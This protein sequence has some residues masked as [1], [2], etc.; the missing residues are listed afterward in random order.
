MKLWQKQH[1]LKA[2]QQLHSGELESPISVATLIWAVMFC[3]LALG[4]VAVYS[5][6]TFKA[7]VTYN[8]PY[9]FVKKHSIFVAVA[10]G[11]TLF[12][13]QLPRSF[14]KVMALPSTIFVAA[15]M[16]FSLF[17]PLAETAGGATRWLDL[18]FVRFQPSE[19]IKVCLPLCCAY[20]FSR[21]QQ[22]ALVTKTLL[23]TGYFVTILM[24]QPDFGTSSLLLGYTFAGLFLAGVSWRIL[25]VLTSSGLTFAVLAIA[26]SE[27][28]MRRVLSFL[29]P[30]SQPDTN[31]FQIIQSYLGINAGGIL[32]LGIG[33]SKQKL[34]F[35][36][37]PHTDFILS[38]VG[39]EMGLLGII[40]LILLFFSLFFCGIETARRCRDSF[41]KHL[42]I[43]VT[44]IIT[45]QAIF[46][47]A[48]VLGMLPTKGI[49]LPF[50]SSGATALVVF[51]ALVGLLINLATPNK[52]ISENQSGS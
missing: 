12:F 16:L 5:A 52:N 9:F 40:T 49:S 7:G 13:S 27:Y 20:M 24:L 41:D 1:H 4:L 35:L 43:G 14:I 32:G 2:R 30:W 45:L 29:D 10:V 3:L 11:V 50:I 51:A 48:V 31:G 33:E 44:L 8:D 18:G 39:E 28:R 6:S 19:L 34:L 37:A 47:I 15:L 26:T 23:I 38:V 46:N 25:L 21:P 17:S 42:G 22:N 36:P